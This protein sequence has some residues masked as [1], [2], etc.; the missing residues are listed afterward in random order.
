MS[1]TQITPDGI[2]FT[3]S[4]NN[5]ATVGL[6]TTLINFD[7][8]ARVLKGVK[9]SFVAVGETPPDE[10]NRPTQSLDALASV[11]IKNLKNDFVTLEADENTSSFTLTFPSVQGGTN[12]YLK[13]DGTGALSWNSVGAPV[14]LYH[15]ANYGTL[16]AFYCGAHPVS[17]FNL[18][19]ITLAE[20]GTAFYK[21]VSNG[22]SSAI[23]GSQGGWVIMNPNEPLAQKVL[24]WSQGTSSTY[25]DLQI[26]ASFLRANDD[27]F[28][29]GLFFFGNDTIEDPDLTGI[30]ATNISTGIAFE[31]RL[32]SIPGPTS[33]L[34]P[35]SLMVYENGVLMKTWD[36]FPSGNS[37]YTPR[38]FQITRNDR[39][40]RFE[41]LPEFA[42]RSGRLGHDSFVVEYELSAGFN[43]SGSR[44]GVSSYNKSAATIYYSSSYT[45]IY[46]IESYAI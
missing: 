1:K 29:K 2:S 21:G 32:N 40:V 34:K 28:Q 42:G 23:I 30:P 35:S 33:T 39:T 3:D 38:K 45:T 16:K 11:S 17:T 14:G 10:N 6:S 19:R 37:T 4:A 12:T 5:A 26:T 27:G 25:W 31:I 46:L 43:P 41:A 15:A 44:W 36:N 9:T 20:T 8:P 7:K 22:S 24:S 18:S 13:N